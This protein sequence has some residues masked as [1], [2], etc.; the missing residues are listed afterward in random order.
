MIV[1]RALGV[2]LMAAGFVA[3]IVDAVKSIASAE[4]II[5]PLSQAW[6]QFHRA[7]LNGAQALIEQYTLP[8]L[9][10]PVAVTILY[11]PGWIVFT[12]LGVAVYYLGRR[13]RSSRA[14]VSAD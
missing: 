6:Y 9:W 14:F 2:L 11:L 7:S 1:L 12:A 4:L 10:D 8:V 13:R 3:L 5:T